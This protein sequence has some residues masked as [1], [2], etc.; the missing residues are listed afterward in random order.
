MTEMNVFVVVDT[1]FPFL[2]LPTLVHCIT[3]LSFQP[4]Q[5]IECELVVVNTTVLFPSSIQFN[6]IQSTAIN[7]KERG[8]RRLKTTKKNPPPTRRIASHRSM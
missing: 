2:F 7:I 3:Y 4:S 6:S 5:S 8:G 1:I